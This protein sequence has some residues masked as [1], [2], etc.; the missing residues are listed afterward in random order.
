V[1]LAGEAETDDTERK[2]IQI[3]LESIFLE[4]QLLFTILPI[5]GFAQ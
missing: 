5:P 1:E 3:R 4:F 2:T